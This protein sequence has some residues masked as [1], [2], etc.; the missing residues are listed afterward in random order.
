MELDL[1]ELKI[2][3]RLLTNRLN[4]DYDPVVD[5]LL[6]KVKEQRRR[7]NQK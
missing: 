6:H 3:E 4:A 5:E 7:E 2:L 1:I